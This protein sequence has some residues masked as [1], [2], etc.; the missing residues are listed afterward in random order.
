MLYYL[1]S[2]R[3]P[4][5]KAHVIQQLNMSQAFAT[6]GED[7]QFVTLRNGGKQPSW[8]ELADHYGLT[9]EFGVRFVPALEENYRFSVPY[10]P[11]LDHQVYTYWLLCAYLSRNLRSG[12]VLYS[13]NLYPTRFFL[14]ILRTLGLGDEISVWFEQ[15][16]IDRDTT[17]WFYEQLDGVVCISEGQKRELVRT[18]PIDPEKLL[19]AHDGADLNGYEGRSM[20]ASRNQ[21]SI[22]LDEKVVMYT[23]HL[24]PSKDV[25]SF[26]RAA[27]DF[28]ATCYIVGGYSEDVSRIK[29]EIDIPENVTFT[30][31]VPPSKVPIYQTAAD[32]LVATVAENPEMDYFSP[33]KLFEYMAAGKPIVV[34]RKPDYEEVLTHGVNALFV[35]PESSEDIANTVRTLL[36]DAQFRSDL[37]QRA[38]QDVRQ[39]SWENRA[40]WILENI[41]ARS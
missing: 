40:K 28:D 4:S 3:L 18:R 6:L 34:T 36:S 39:Y 1:S 25:E 33:L 37:G 5:K 21:L 16:Q 23:G 7:V 8:E 31:F 26:V 17:A 12:D 11:N 9:S 14:R 10:V 29:S 30:G 15:H 24:Y 35:D 2:T 20:E 38:R 32:V 13:R 22:D 41:R 19:V 27:G